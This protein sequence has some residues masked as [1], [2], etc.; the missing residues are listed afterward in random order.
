MKSIIIFGK[1]PSVLKCT[2]KIVDD[3]DD[4]AICNYPVLNDFFSNLIKNRTINYHFAN[5]ADFD[6]RYN[7]D[8]NNLLKIQGI[9]NTHKNNLYINFLN[10][11]KIFKNNINASNRSFFLEN[12]DLDPS[13]GTMALNFIINLKKYDKICIVGFDNLEKGKQTYYYDVK[14]YNKSLLY[15]IGGNIKNNGIFN[16]ISGHNPEKTKLYYEDVIKN[17]NNIKFTFI[18]HLKLEEQNNLVII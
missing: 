8:I 5:C 1:G 18:T 6:H 15:L 4:I 2:K 9:Y 16:I 17:N 13:T 3:Y 12:Y 10:N 11:K 7:D 14:D